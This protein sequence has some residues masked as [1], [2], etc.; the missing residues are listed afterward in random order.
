M[1]LQ[2]A[3]DLHLEFAQNRRFIK[4]NPIQPKAEVLVLAGDVMP[5]VTMDKHMDFIDYLSDHF[6][7]TYWVP[8]NH[9][10][11][12]FDLKKKA[13]K[14]NEYIRSNVRLVNN[15]IISQ[16]DVRFIFSTLWSR[17]SPSNQ[18]QLQ[19]S[20]TDFQAIKC[21]GEPFAVEQF[22]DLHQSC[23]AFITKELQRKTK[24]KTVV[25]THHVPTLIHYPER[26]QDTAWSQ[27]FAVELFDLIEVT[28]PNSWIYGHHHFNTPDFT[29]CKT[30]MLT[31]QLGYVKYGGDKYFR[32]DKTIVI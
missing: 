6:K 28:Q 21:N 22:N 26:H 9:E 23:L 31:N 17:I 5:F 14:I 3:S 16:D 12:Q 15:L 4:D 20:I 7:M 24:E 32:R 1:I 10:Y 13:G 18:S 8:G 29:L 25:V 27:A 19:R 11:Y 30:K 2:Y